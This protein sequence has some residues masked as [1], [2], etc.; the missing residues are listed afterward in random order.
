MNGWINVWMCMGVWING[1]M[2]VWM[3]GL[4]DRLMAVGR[5]GGGKGGV[6]GY[7]YIAGEPGTHTHSGHNF[8]SPR[9]IP[10]REDDRS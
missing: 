2:D 5:R 6:C 10:K 3:Y 4:M 8:V 1:R 7:L 9:K